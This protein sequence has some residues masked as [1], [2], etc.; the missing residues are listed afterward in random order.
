MSKLFRLT[1]R[2]PVGHE[3]V[4]HPPA[5]GAVPADVGEAPLVVAVGGAEGDLLDS[6]VDDQPLRLVVHHAEAVPVD[7]QHGADRL[8][9]GVLKESLVSRDHQ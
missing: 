4:A 8:P 6:L 1:H 7:V 9:L 3:A 2:L 5:R